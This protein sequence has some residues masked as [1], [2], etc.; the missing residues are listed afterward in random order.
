MNKTN[1]DQLAVKFK[2]VTDIFRV[3]DLRKQELNL[4]PNPKKRSSFY[5]KAHFNKAFNNDFIYPN[6]LLFGQATLRNTYSSPAMN[7]L[8]KRIRNTI[9]APQGYMMLGVDIVALELTLLG[10]TLKEMYDITSV[11]DDLKSGACP[12][13][14]TIDCFSDAFEY[15]AE[16][17]PERNLKD[18]AKTVNYALLYGSSPKAM[19]TNTLCIPMDFLPSV[20]EAMDA[21]F[22]GISYLKGWLC[23]ELDKKNYFRNMYGTKIYSPDYCSV[24]YW[25]QSGGA[26]HATMV[27]AL[28][29][30]QFLLLFNECYPILQN[31]DEGQFIT[32]TF[33][34]EWGQMVVETVN[35]TLD[36]RFE[37]LYDL[38]NFVEVDIKWG[39]HWG[40]TH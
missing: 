39:Q 1:K 34:D 32:N 27:M 12:K 37:V 26:E 31:H 9:S 11:W 23:S 33:T 29:Y 14:R 6:L 22:E 20:T 19:V 36:K 5:S 40:E 17:N 15:I 35:K 13:Q 25:C 7:Q 16:H 38:P 2:E 30:R 10:Y 24:N 28:L 4:A 3:K 8:D 21:R 18:L